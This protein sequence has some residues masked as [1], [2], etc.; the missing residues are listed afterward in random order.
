VFVVVG[1]GAAFFP[2]WALGTD[3]ELRSIT[4]PWGETLLVG[5][6][7]T[8][9]ILALQSLGILG[10]VGYIGLA[11]VVLFRRGAQREAMVL[12]IGL[13]WFAFTLVEE[14]LVVAGVVDWPFLSDFGFLGFVIAVGLSI[15]NEAIE[16]EAQ[17]VELQS[18]LEM[19]VRERTVELAQAQASL[20][21]QAEQQAAAAERSRLARELHDVVTQILFAINLIAGSLGRLWRTD[22]EAASR[23]TDELQRLTRGALA[24]MRILLRELRPESIARTDLGALVT[25]LADGLGA[26]HDIPVEVSTRIHGPLPEEVHLAIYR[27]AQEATNNVA[28]HADAS[29][30]VIDLEGNYEGVRLRV[31]DD[32]E[33]FDTG[34]VGG[35]SMGLAIMRERACDVGAALEVASSPGEGTSVEVTWGARDRLEPV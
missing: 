34:G 4:L 35:A 19:A 7:A 14:T 17:L 25:Q 3:G 31:E 21:A 13:G 28:K 23:T 15:T 5:P 11:N 12:A 24:E 2:D 29:R 1:V 33:G 18:N 20:V 8:T 9:S 16:T 22:P 6:E 27:I 26:R 30:L 32:G 10:M